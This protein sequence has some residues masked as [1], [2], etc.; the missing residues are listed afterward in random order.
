MKK[1][2]LCIA[3]S[4]TLSLVA[5]GATLAQDTMPQQT[6]TTTTTQTTQTTLNADGSYTVIQY[7]TDKE[8]MVNLSPTTMIP[9]ASGTA[10]IMR[11]GTSTAVDLNL[12]G[13]TGDTTGYNVYAVDSSGKATLLGPVTVDNGTAKLTTTTPLDKFMLV[14]SPEANLTTVGANN[15]VV[16]RSAVPEGFAVVPVAQSGPK[17]GAPIGERVVATTTAGATSVYNAPLLGIPNFRRGTDTHLKVRFAGAMS[18]TRANVFL[19]PRKDGPTEI[20]MR[21]HDLKLAPANSRL[22]LWAVAPDNTYTKIGQVIN[23][24]GRNET[25]IKG[26]T[27]LKD[28]GLFVTAETTDAPSPTSPIVGTIVV[29]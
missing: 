7:P 14:L 28:F 5:A 29:R 1:Q 8:V 19:E 20:K 17:D 11:S 13:L 9:G 26:E 23:T 2:L 15:N 21:F 12:I 24:G 10:K 18:G 6:T 27:A 16:L 25:E 22:I 3:G 4:F